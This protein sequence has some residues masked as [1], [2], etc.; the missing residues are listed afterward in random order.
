MKCGIQESYNN[1]II[2]TKSNGTLKR[3]L[4]KDFCLLL[5][6]LIFTWNKQLED[7]E[8]KEVEAESL[9]K[10]KSKCESKPESVQIEEEMKVLFPNYHE[11]DFSDFQ[12]I[13]DLADSDEAANESPTEYVT[14]NERDLQFVMNLHQDLL[15][16]FTKT[17]WLNSGKDKRSNVNYIQPLM[18]KY[19]VFRR[20]LEKTV[21]SFDNRLDN[22]L[23]ASLNVLVSV[24]R[25]DGDVSD[26]GKDANLREN[27]FNVHCFQLKVR[28]LKQRVKKCKTFIRI[29]I[30]KKLKPLTTFLKI[31]ESTWKLNCWKSGQI[32]RH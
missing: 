17:E 29:Q 26:F 31:S 25:K 19:K 32:S 18:E 20:I 15:K 9:Y 30:L 2:N 6:E 5:D 11:K 28:L 21:H 10:T 1:C 14:V 27:S 13:V 23:M 4:F 7:K 24:I 12:R 22:K 3:E 16:N 8:Q